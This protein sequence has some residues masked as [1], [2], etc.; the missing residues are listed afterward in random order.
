M[1]T[2]TP[3]EPTP[4]RR[5]T[6]AASSFPI[7]RT[8]LC[9][10]IGF[11][12]GLALTFVGY[13]V[14]YYSLYQRLPETFDFATIQ[15]LHQVTPV[16]FFMDGFALI[17][18]VVGAIVGRLQDRLIFHSNHLEEVVA[19]RTRDLTRSQE[20]YQ[21]AA[22]GANDGLWDWDL[23]TGKVYYSA[24]WRSAL[25]EDENG[26]G[27]TPEV[28]L[29]RVHPEDRP[30]LEARIRSHLHG[31]TRHL[32]AEY[33]IRH[34]DGSYRWMLSRG[35]AVRDGTTGKP[36]R[37]AG[38]QTDIDERKRMEEQL[39]D[40]A[41]HDALTRLPNRTL[42]FD[43]LSQA[44]GRAQKRGDAES[45]AIVFVD[46]DRFKN[47]NDSLGHVIGDQVIQEVAARFRAC[48]E[49]AAGELG[50]E[51]GAERRRARRGN[52][53]WTLARM[54]GDEFTVLLENIG[55]IRDATRIVDDLEQRF[56]EP[57]KVSGR[58][59]FVT[60]S[61]GIALGPG[62]YRLPEELVRDADTAMYRA[63]EGG[64]ARCVIFDE[65]MLARVQEELR[66]ETDLHKAM[67]RDEFH[68]VYQP[69][70]EL[71]TRR[72]MGFEALLRWQ[73][74]ERGLIPP[75]RFIPMAEETGLIIQ[76]GRWMFIEA[77]R[78]LR[79]WHDLDEKF[80]GLMLAT[81]LSLRQIYSPDLVD[82]VTALV[83]EAGLDPSLLHFEI[84]ENT[85]IE[86]PAQVTQVLLRLK[87]RGFKVAI[88]D[89]GTGY[90]SLAALESLPVDILK[91]DQ[92]FVARMGE[93]ERTRRIVAT[94]VGLA[95]ALDHDIVAEGIESETQLKQ[96]KALGCTLGQGHLFSPPLA[97]DEVETQVL[98]HYYARLGDGTRAA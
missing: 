13:L 89:F 23:V 76:L 40:L 97:G 96:L 71:A 47:I 77:L 50:R 29:G 86:H 80:R 15:G 51:N 93:N 25:G 52:L 37:M 81:N 95:R 42:F 87:R 20:R 3:P 74:P 45:L 84:T 43:R 12:F 22:R 32:D 69:I 65:K 57:M 61:I 8:L 88:D 38:S 5:R 9:G 59:L 46:V 44:F 49:K 94:I 63:K 30:G 75:A 31:G 18:A 2:A 90:S 34:A 17:L 11:V 27:D 35:M 62:E 56:R 66:L 41:L 98:A 60:L 1:P 64:R 7:S 73:H 54:G 39:K 33:R 24:R 78:Q 53:E 48:I 85:L 91:M 14:D 68:V 67:A 26:A 6:P 19:A 16:H 70:L 36:Y 28:W 21:L 58:E 82:E 83:G 72:L 92:V 55:S 79:H 4:R 10:A